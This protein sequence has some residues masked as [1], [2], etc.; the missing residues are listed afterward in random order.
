MSLARSPVQVAVG[1]VLRDDGAV[2]LGQR[3][4]GKPYAGWWEFPG[5]K[6]EQG[7]SVGE[8]LIRELH[9]E[10]GLRVASSCPWVVREFVYPHAHVRLHFHRVFEFSGE[11][12]GREGQAFAW[13]KPDEI[14]VAPLLPATVPVLSWLQLA[15]CSLQCTRWDGDDDSLLSAMQRAL[16]TPGYWADRRPMVLLDL[17]QMPASRFEALYY[18]I[19]ALCREL[20]GQLLVGSGHPA[21]FAAAAEGMLIDT[22]LLCELEQRPV[23]RLVGARCATS[24]DLSRAAELGLDFALL[25]DPARLVDAPIPALLAVSAATRVETACQQ[26]AHGVAVELAFWQD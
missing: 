24:A 14:D 7:E 6:L 1:V 8:A 19:R 11:P 13:R 16:E 22:H 4:V 10:L 20:G 18:R 26:G 21:S 3:P 9:E 5:G 12:H 17:P 23:G 2:L 25:A 15:Q